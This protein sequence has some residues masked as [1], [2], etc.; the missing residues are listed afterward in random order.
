MFWCAAEFGFPKDFSTIEVFLYYI[1]CFSWGRVESGG[2][3]LKLGQLHFAHVID[4]KPA[5]S[6]AIMNSFH[7]LIAAK[8]CCKGVLQ[9]E[10]CKAMSVVLRTRYHI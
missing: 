10:T 7:V 6:G 2:L 9:R 4:D 1:V 3:N 5:G 8:V